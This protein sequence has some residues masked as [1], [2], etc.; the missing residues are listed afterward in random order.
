LNG[1]I[2]VGKRADFTVMAVDPRTVKPEEV[3]DIP[4]VMTV[5][6][7]EIVYASPNGVVG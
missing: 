6:G 3:P 2:E 5:G 7:G 1:T 4:T